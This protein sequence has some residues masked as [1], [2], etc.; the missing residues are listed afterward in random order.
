MKTGFHPSSRRAHVIIVGAGFGGLKVAKHLRKTPVDI[1]LIDRNNYHL[2]QP[3]LYQVATAGLSAGDIA[4]PIRKILCKSTNTHVWMGEVTQIDVN[5]HQIWIGSRILSYDYLVLAP[6]SQYNYF[7]H[8]EWS[9]FAPSLKSV[10]N[11]L[12][13]R[14]KILCAFEQAEMEENPQKKRAWMTFIIVGGGPTGVEMAGAIGELAHRGLRR[15]FRTLDP[16]S[17]R[18]II[19]E[20]AARILAPFTPELS[21]KSR[22]ALE[23]LGVEIRTHAMVEKID[24]DGIWIHGE[25]LSSKTVLWAAGV[26]ASPLL[27]QLPGKID[28]SGKIEVM[29]DLS[30]PGHPQVFVIGDAA[31]LLQ[32]GKPLPGLA[33]VAMQQGEYVAKLIHQRAIG[34]VTHAAFVYKDKGQLATIGRAFAIA[35]FGRVKF[36]GFF[37]WLVWIFIHIF[38]LIGF[39][40]RILVFIQWAWA[41]FTFD[42]GSRVIIEESTL[43]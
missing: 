41:Y 2:F 20:A 16:A 11:A 23:N 22:Q 33:P 25:L 37:A 18:V 32:N 39:Q 30:L 14:T 15:N 8:E 36:S 13:I 10:E 1:T 5:N 29:P 12:A 38:F 26:Q 6:G 27:K 19:V 40:N 31:L 42:R 43:K 9:T 35:E 24:A 17:A 3:L 4:E 34:Q 21:E 7:G 28:K